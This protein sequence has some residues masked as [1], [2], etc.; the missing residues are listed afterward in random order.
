[1]T[2]E[3]VQSPVR[4]LRGPTADGP[5]IDHE[6]VVIGAGITGL[7]AAWELA[8]RGIDVMVL[9]A[10]DRS[11][12]VMMT[13]RQGDWV[14]E[15]GPTSMIATPDVRALIAD[16]GIEKDVTSVMPAARHRYVAR[17]SALQPVPMT[18]LALVRTPLLSARAKLRLLGEPFVRRCAER[19]ESV[20]SFVRRRLGEEPLR[21]IGAPFVSGIYAGDAEVLSARHA[22]PAMHALEREHGSLLIGAM[23]SAWAKRRRGVP[24]ES[25]PESIS[26]RGGLGHLASTLAAALVGRVTY[27]AR[28]E[29]VA[30]RASG[31]WAVDVRRSDGV[32]VSV[33]ASH[34]VL[35]TSAPALPQVSASRMCQDA[36]A[37]IAS[38]P[39]A[40]VATVAIGV[41]RR[42]VSH[43][44]DGFGFLVA[45][46]ERRAVLGA[47]FT[48]TMFRGRCPDDSVLLT[49][50][51]GG[52]KAP[53]RALSSLDDTLPAL[54]ADLRDL[55][56]ITGD[57]CFVAHALH[58][59]AI[60]QFGSA[61]ERTLAAAACLE[62]A[63]PSLTLAG[64][65]RTG[66]AVGSC[67]KS[68]RGA[69]ARAGS[70]VRDAR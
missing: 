61:H 30:P 47:L 16:L 64:S 65:W 18:P 57:P 26:L 37:T 38:I 33:T 10:A 31:T 48:S 20:A 12:G 63:F 3:V 5:S 29:R 40:P 21:N 32:H 66:V 42:Q 24:R 19:D 8:R 2:T 45:D 27:G 51:V 50:F 11:G 34:V 62:L 6:V 49:C 15:R 53:W 44:L 68:G 22:M 54:M 70:H 17:K 25:R 58:E 56:G 60:P 69:A 28:V 43:A 39:H 36:V 52:T 35:A 46:G 67:V 41:R 55:L 9:D 1:M 23:R 14:V 59:K 13:E 4:G 7:T